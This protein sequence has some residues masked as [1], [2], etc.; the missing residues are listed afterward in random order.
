MATHDTEL[1]H[2]ESWIRLFPII[3]LKEKL[4]E[5]NSISIIR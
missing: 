2:A 4:K 5:M 3:I 1:A